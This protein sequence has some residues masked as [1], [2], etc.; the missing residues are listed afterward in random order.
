MVVLDTSTLI[1]LAKCDL[2][3]LL[4]EK[5]PLVMPREVEREALVKSELYDAK[6]IA[7][8]IKDKQIQ[9]LQLA[10]ARHRNQVQEDFGIGAG[11]AEAL[12]LAKEH[13]VPLG[14]DD[15]P[16]I[17]AAKIMGIPFLTAMNILVELC[18]KNR[19]GAETALSKLDK[20]ESI[21]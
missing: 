16:A 11:E 10:H 1:L 2:L 3:P 21:G 8:M 18:Q 7:S 14:T 6:V 4:A 19:L 9:V 5:T 12:L 13:G 15:W 20:L 17:K